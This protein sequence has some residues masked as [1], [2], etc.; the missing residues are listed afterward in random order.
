[1]SA[2]DS[3]L[4]AG[5][6]GASLGTE[7]AKSLG[8]A[9]GYKIYGCDIS[10]HAYGLHGPEFEDTAKIGRASYVEQLLELCLQ[11]RVACVVPGGEE[12]LR[13]IVG[14]RDSFARAGV[15]IA[16]NDAE[17]IRTCVDKDLLFLELQR[18][19]FPTPWTRAIMDPRA[20]R[21]DDIPGFPCIVKPSTVSG[22]SAFVFLVRTFEELSSYANLILDACGPAV[23]Q[24]YVA[25]D[26]G[27][28]TIG[29]L[30]LQEAGLVGS[31]AMRRIFDA[32]LSVAMR[33]ATGLISSGY[34]QGLIDSF[35]DVCSQ[36][37]RLAE[38]LGSIGPLNIQGRMR[39]G[40]LLPFEV[41]PRFSAST[42]L[43]AMAGFNEVDIF[44][45]HALH[46]AT[47]APGPIRTGYYLRSL[48]E[49]F[50]LNGPEDR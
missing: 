4:I 6:G 24:E 14:A 48:T 16:I 27:E 13:S 32:K 34:S 30:S 23:A 37:E 40:V 12:P 49:R 18:L 10:P 1:M 28:F 43:R 44:L 42:Y 20:L 50:E 47:P 22:G 39:D 7:I 21:K 11:W 15:A 2:P 38:A 46:G 29:V 19:G 35:P 25:V 3:V 17:L 45:K 31:I 9:G 36:A 8:L 5:V 41:N 26:E 33:S